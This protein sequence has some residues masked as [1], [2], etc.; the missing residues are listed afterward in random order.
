MHILERYVASLFRFSSE[1]AFV[2]V[3]GAPVLS[4]GFSDT[5]SSGLVGGWGSLGFLLSAK[6]PKDFEQC[7]QNW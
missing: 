1:R 6:S 2:G 7:K 3:V 5:R 4:L